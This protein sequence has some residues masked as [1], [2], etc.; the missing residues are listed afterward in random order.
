MKTALLIFILV[1]ML[2]WGCAHIDVVRDKIRDNENFYLA[3]AFGLFWIVLG[4]VG[5]GCWFATLVLPYFLS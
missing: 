4:V 5:L 2:L 1:T 3:L